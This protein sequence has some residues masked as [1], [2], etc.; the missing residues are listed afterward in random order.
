MYG[1]AYSRNHST[2]RILQMCK[3]I[4]PPRFSWF[5]NNTLFSDLVKQKNINVIM[6]T[7]EQERPFNRIL[8]ISIVV[9]IEE[10]PHEDSKIY[11][12]ILCTAIPRPLTAEQ[13][14]TA[15]GKVMLV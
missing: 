15:T 10:W 11:L 8:F 3:H 4:F 14:D 6:Y 2:L 13:I 12:A 1:E 7:W 5:M 9:G